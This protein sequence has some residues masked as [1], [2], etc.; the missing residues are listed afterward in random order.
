VYGYHP[1]EQ[2]VCAFDIVCPVEGSPSA[3][4]EILSVVS[5]V[6]ADLSLA[7]EANCFVRLN[8][9]KLLSGLVINSGVPDELRER[10]YDV[11]REGAMW[12]RVQRTNQL[13]SIGLAETTVSNL[14]SCLEL[15]GS[16]AAV[17]SALRHLAR[18]KN[19]AAAMIKEALNELDALVHRAHSMG[20]T[21]SLVV[22]PSLVFN[23]GQYSGVVY[24]LV[25]RKK[26]SLEALAA[27]G[28]YDRLVSHFD[29]MFNVQ[30][31]SASAYPAAGAAGISFSLDRLAAALPTDGEAS[32]VSARV[33]ICVE[34]ASAV[35]RRDADE[36]AGKLWS[37]GI[38]CLLCAP[39][40]SP[41]D[42]QESARKDGSSSTSSLIVI[43][44]ETADGSVRVRSLE[45]DRFQERRVA[46]VDVVDYLQKNFSG[47][48]DN[49]SGQQAM[50]S[51]YSGSGLGGPQASIGGRAL[52]E[53]L[54]SATSS[55][56]S[57]GA[58]GSRPGV[59]YRHGCLE[60]GKY[61]AAARKKLET[62]V[63]GRITPLLSR[64]APGAVV[65]VL[66]VSLPSAVIRAAAA[67]LDLEDDESFGRSVAA[68]RERHSRHR[69]ELAFL[70]EEIQ[71]L[72]DSNAVVVLYAAE[73]H[74]FAPIIPP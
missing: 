61:S 34:G 43:V 53:G 27:G 59:T 18:R 46:S 12:T 11:I 7:N 38:A 70:C 2:M 71:R 20:V 47:D 40:R 68:L 57:G 33:F 5:E 6:L 63:S 17:K 14:L 35:V 54:A 37:A 52:A 4:A 31:N 45:R 44:R 22:S 21:C 73:E 65:E 3:D 48:A 28:R 39:G 32:T 60:K 67:F 29:T 62:T 23:H 1:R 41:D 30:D 19:S 72:A 16:P 50:S 56:A 49:T 26:R 69:K 25:R 42:V 64:L 24:Q 66:T 9:T 58:S 15:E 55:V 8:H 51:S 13:T 36:I 74:N 10:V